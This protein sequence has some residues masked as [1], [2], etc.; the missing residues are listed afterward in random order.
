MKFEIELEAE[1]VEMFLFE[2]S[3][4]KTKCHEPVKIPKLTDASAKEIEDLRKFFENCI[5]EL[6]YESYARMM[7]AEEERG[8]FLAKLAA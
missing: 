3:Y 8:G 5:V 4:Y 1:I 7:Y 2:K 6:A